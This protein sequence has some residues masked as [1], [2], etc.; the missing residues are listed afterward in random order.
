MLGE[1]RVF[2]DLTGLEGEPD[3]ST[4]D[5]EGHLWNAFWGGK[6][7]IR[8]APGGS[9]ERIVR[10]AAPRP[11]CVAFGGPDLKTMYAT[12]A[13]MGLSSSDLKEFPGSGGVFQCEVDMAGLPEPR[14]LG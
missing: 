5:S 4:I 14:F 13:T 10:L 6:R 8:F 9:V 1:A 7:L 12:S 2:A 3:G 11:T